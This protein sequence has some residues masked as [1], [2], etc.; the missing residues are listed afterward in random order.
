ME[1]PSESVAR[2]ALD[3]ALLDRATNS[4]Q[5]RIMS[6]K[7]ITIN[8]LAFGGEVVGRDGGK[9]VF[10]PFTA[11][12]DTVRVKIVSEHPRFERGELL[13]VL[14]TSQNRV[15]PACPVFGL[16]G[17]CQWQH[18]DYDAQLRWKE[19]ILSETLKRIG[20]ISLPEILPILSAPDP[21][22]YRSRIQ[23]KVGSKGDIGFFGLKTHHV[24]DVEECPIADRRLN[25]KLAA[26]RSNGSRPASDFEIALGG[27]AEGNGIMVTPSG[28]EAVFSQVNRAQ[29]ELLVAT[30]VGFA[31]GNAEEAFTRKKIVT[32]IYA[33][34]GNFSFP[35]AQRA[36]CVVA[37]E[38][39]REAVR[40][41]EAL[42]KERGVENIEWIQGT[43][44]WGL[45]KIFRAKRKVD[46]LVLDPPRRGAKEILDLVC[47]IRPRLIVYVSCDPVTLARDLKDLV[48]R[49]YRLEKVQPIDMFPQTYHIESVAQLSLL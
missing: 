27:C 26:L 31:F 10:V 19:T 15:P 25:A 17:G 29:N 37:V 5:N 46:L 39:N 22:H 43:A 7:F 21:W 45:K 11:P 38:E 8:S 3:A 23:L 4:G 41:G 13:D 1:F 44:E 47:V 35:L 30:V 49:H 40:R 34:T 33:G 28:R 20:K 42:S 2:R 9:V 16:C 48:R 32:E 12:G 36:G 14:E 6:E 18:L 24:I